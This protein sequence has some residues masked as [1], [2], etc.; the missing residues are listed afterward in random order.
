MLEDADNQINKRSITNGEAQE[1]NN[2]TLPSRVI[3]PIS[4]V[5]LLELMIW[6]KACS[7]HLSKNAEEFA[8]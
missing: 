8:C 2:H 4:I 3:E 6:S 1:I 5:N 7:Y